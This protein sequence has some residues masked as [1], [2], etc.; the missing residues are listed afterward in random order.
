MYQ[1]IRAYSGGMAFRIPV[2]RTLTLFPRNMGLE[3]FYLI[4]LIP[5]HLSI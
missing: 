3:G 4:P 2:V 5:V 1:Y